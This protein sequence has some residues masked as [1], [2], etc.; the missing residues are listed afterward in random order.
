VITVQPR[1]I[2]VAGGKGGV[3]K[4]LLTANLAAALAQSGYRT[5]AVDLDLGGS[6]LH[7]FLG[8]ANENPGVGDFLKA[9]TA[10]LT[11]ML[12]P[13]SIEDL[14]FIPGDGRTPFMANINFAQKKRLIR[15]LKKLPADFVVADLGAGSS[16]NVLDLFSIEKHGVVITSP[17]FPALMNMMVF[18]KNFVLRRFERQFRQVAP[19]KKILNRFFKQPITEDNIALS[20]LI[21]EVGE[22]FPEQAENMRQLSRK[23]RPRIIYNQ[24]ADVSEIQM[25]PKIGQNMSDRLGLSVE[26]FGFVPS[27][28]MAAKSVRERGVLFELYPESGSYQQIRRVADRIAR[29]WDKNIPNSA[30]HLL[31]DIEKNHRNT[32]S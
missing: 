22:N 8:Y 25:I 2:P 1:I 3:G 12:L 19:V 10:E 7:S 31:K 23:Y 17:E 13:T 5:I 20:A 27:D 30:E 15:S 28:E 21:D 14:Y 16:Y 9:R 24:V 29:L 11:D 32:N 18:L 26:H 4:S 6:N